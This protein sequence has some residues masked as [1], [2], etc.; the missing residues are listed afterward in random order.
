VG[1]RLYLYNTPISRKYSKEQLKQMLKG[2][3]GEIL[4]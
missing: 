3:K 2:V 1:G 4:T